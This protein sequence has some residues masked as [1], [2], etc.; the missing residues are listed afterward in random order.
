ME[1]TALPTSYLRTLAWMLPFLFCLHQVSFV[2]SGMSEPP[3][4]RQ[5]GSEPPAYQHYQDTQNNVSVDAYVSRVQE[6]VLKMEFISRPP[7]M[8]RVKSV[9]LI[10]PEGTVYGPK[11]L[12]E[13]SEQAAKNLGRLRPVFIPKQQASKSTKTKVGSALLSSSLMALSGLSGSSKST[14]NTAGYH[15]AKKSSSGLSTLGAL[16]GL[17]PALVTGGSG[18]SS[19][20]ASGEGEWVYPPTA[21]TGV[22]SSVAEFDASHIADTSNP[23][24]LQTTMQYP[25]GKEAVYSF[26]LYPAGFPAGDKPPEGPPR[27][28]STWDEI[29][30]TGSSSKLL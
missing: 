15:A 25:D 28:K 21:G 11:T 7:G 14:Y 8:A 24:K 22:F 16:G 5:E 20:G 12:F 19:K 9:Q 26:V 17:T 30:L 13:I 18:S 2:P 4:E 27:E 10:S 23:W 3:E 29:Q 1:W 6:D